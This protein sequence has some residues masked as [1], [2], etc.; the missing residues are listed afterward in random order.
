MFIKLEHSILKKHLDSP[1]EIAYLLNQIVVPLFLVRKILKDTSSDFLLQIIDHLIKLHRNIGISTD[2]QV[3]DTI[4]EILTRR[5]K[6]Y[7]IEITKVFIEN[8][9][10]HSILTRLFWQYPKLYL[11]NMD[12]AEQLFCGDT[13]LVNIFEDPDRSIRHLKQFLPLF[14]PTVIKRHF[15][16]IGYFYRIPNCVLHYSRFMYEFN[17]VDLVFMMEN[18]KIFNSILVDSVP[19]LGPLINLALPHLLKFAPIIYK[20]NKIICLLDYVVREDKINDVCDLLRL[21]DLDIDDITALHISSVTMCEN[22]VQLLKHL[23]IHFPVPQEY[24]YILRSSKPKS[25][26]KI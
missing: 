15:K 3:L 10:P 23:N 8:E 17:M 22:L 1:Q 19:T 24:E 18:A 4:V 13:I 5:N 16:D 20:R 6:K 21:L 7:I 2:D 11:K 12:V 14:P 26:R 25:A 9:E